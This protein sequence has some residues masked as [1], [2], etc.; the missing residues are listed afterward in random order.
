M[1]SSVR[2]VRATIGRMP[3]RAHSSMWELTGKQERYSV[4][5][6]F[7][8]LAIAAEALVPVA[9]GYAAAPSRTVQARQNVDPRGA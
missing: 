5:S 1:F 7:R 4:P 6:A 3:I 8:M 2:S 9:P